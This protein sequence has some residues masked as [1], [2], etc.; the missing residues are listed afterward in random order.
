[1]EEIIMKNI[2][3]IK[4]LSR[5]GSLVTFDISGDNGISR[6]RSKITKLDDEYFY[7]NDKKFP[8]TIITEINNFDLFKDNSM[9]WNIYF[10]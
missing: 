7:I 2:D 5:V 10:S 6:Y 8:Y 9:N 1:M 3:N 4:Y